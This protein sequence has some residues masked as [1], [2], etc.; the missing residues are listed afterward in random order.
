MKAIILAGGPGNHHYPLAEGCPHPLVPLCNQPFLVSQLVA[1]RSRGIVEIGLSLS[2]TDVGAV[3]DHFGDGSVWGIRL[4]YA[5]DPVPVGPAGAIR[6]HQ[7]LI[8][9]DS[10][11]VTSAST[12]LRGDDLEG[13]LR[14]HGRNG[15]TAT[16]G[17]FPS[18]EGMRPSRFE[19]AVVS[20]EGRVEAFE[21]LHASRDRRRRQVFSG[22]YVFQP[23]VLD[24]IP[25]EGYADLKE[26]LIPKL[27]ADGAVVSAHPLGGWSA[28]IESIEDYVRIHRRLLGEG[29]IQREGLN[30]IDRDVWAADDARIGASAYILGPI[31][32][33][34]QC[35][36]EDGAQLIGPAVIGDGCRIGAGGLVRESILWPGVESRAR[37]RIEYSIVGSNFKVDP[38]RQVHREVVIG[39]GTGAPR[40]YKAD[41]DRDNHGRANGRHC[42]RSKPSRWPVEMPRSWFLRAT[43]RFIDVSAASAALLLGLPLVILI[44]VLVR[45]DSAGPVFYVQ[46]RCGRNGREFS[47]FKFRT[48]KVG[49][50]LLQQQYKAHSSVDGPM[51]KMFDDPRRTRCGRVLRDLGLDEI[52]QLFNVL[53]GDMSLVGPRPLVMDEMQRS[54][55]WRDF[56]LTVKPGITGLLQVAEHR[57]CSFHNWVRCDI[58]YVQ[59][60]SIA[61][62]CRIILKTTLWVA[63]RVARVCWA[64]EDWSEEDDGGAGEP[65]ASPAPATVLASHAAKR[66][67]EMP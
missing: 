61:L 60:W 20:A 26:Q 9:N 11:L 8:G 30:T 2:P 51:F 38:G 17:M 15:A 24:Q 10:F 5:V 49:A 23:E 56:R 39:N 28:R 63:A 7:S 25:G 29:C 44:A 16:L 47:M 36:I 65:I 42:G 48:M 12:Y 40:R 31:L 14:A 18:N 58:E 21:I 46:R 6:Q 45:L 35:V 32:I 50:E 41:G 54:P 19:N 66:Q 34:R 62:D 4:E 53:R 22:V 33:G 3:S 37:A 13:L 64:P 27:C 57:E 59:N 52:P 55:N 1:L 43:K 67:E